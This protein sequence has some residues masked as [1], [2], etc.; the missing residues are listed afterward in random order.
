MKIAEKKTKI[1]SLE[2]LIFKKKQQTEKNTK[3][4]EILELEYKRLNKSVMPML[5][6][7]YQDDINS[8]FN[9]IYYCPDLDSV[10]LESSEK[11]NSFLEN[12][13]DLREKFNDLVISKEDISSLDSKVIQV[14]INNVKSI[15]NDAINFGLVKSW[16]EVRDF[17]EI[18]PNYFFTSSLDEDKQN[19]I[20]LKRTYIL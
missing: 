17:L 5:L 11:E 2:N 12:T 13:L 16:D 14:A 9:Y 20:T 6:F 18:V 4:L 15:I 1:E 19:D 8:K 3:A 7:V 10:K